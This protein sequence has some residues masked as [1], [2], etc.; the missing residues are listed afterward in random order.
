MRLTSFLNKRG[1]LPEHKVEFQ[2]LLPL[3]LKNSVSGKGEKSAENP[4][5][6]EMMVLFSCLKKNEY[7]QSPCGNELDALNKCYKTHQVTVQKEKELMK[8]GILAPGAKNLNHRQIGMLLK[9]FPAK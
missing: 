5:V 4:C 1:W 9:R 2:E 3:K 6:Q 7:N 8:L